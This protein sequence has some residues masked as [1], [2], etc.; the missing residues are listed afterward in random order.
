MVSC[1]AGG[2]IVPS[3]GLF[4][5]KH[6][7]AALVHL[8]NC[9]GNWGWDKDGA[10]SFACV[11]SGPLRGPSCSEYSDA[12]TCSGRGSVDDQ[13]GCECAGPPGNA[14]YG[15]YTGEDCAG[16]PQL[17]SLE[18]EEN[19]RYTTYYIAFGIM[20]TLCFLGCLG[21]AWRCPGCGDG[22]SGI[23]DVGW[24]TKLTLAPFVIAFRTSDFM[25]DWAFFAITLRNGGLFFTLAMEQ[26]GV[27]YAAIHSAA[28][29]FCILGSILF[30]AEIPLGF[31]GRVCLWSN[32]AEKN[33]DSSES[34]ADDEY[35]YVEGYTDAAGYFWI[36]ATTI[37]AL[38]LED[39]PQLYLQRCTF[40]RSGLR[41]LT[42]LQRLL[43]SCQH[44]LCC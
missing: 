2:Y 8:L 20:V 26:E 12:T 43:L 21:V 11:C 23:S 14:F 36:P 33:K 37:L 4:Q 27:N 42:A 31:M 17:M 41:M 24:G 5:C 22:T 1:S 16:A 10:T 13:G 15:N 3:G 28:K 39:A 44:W 19:A 18:D 30:V 7:A 40:R 25:S 35:T 38:L 6:A 32:E 9:S 29:A 34:S